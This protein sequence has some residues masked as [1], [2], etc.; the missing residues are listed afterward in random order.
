M[1][2]DPSVHGDTASGAS[3][4]IILSADKGGKRRPGAIVS[5]DFAGSTLAKPAVG[6]TIAWVSRRCRRLRAVVALSLLAV[7]SAARAEGQRLVWNRDWPRFRPVEYGATG[8]LVAAGLTLELASTQPDEAHWV[9]PLPLDQP[10]R[11]ALVGGNRPTRQVADFV[12][13][14]G[15]MTA[16]FYPQVVDATLVTFVLDGGNFDVAWQLSWM[17]AEAMAVG[18]L[19]TRGA[20]RLFARERPLRRGCGSDAFYDELCPF[21]GTAAS[22]PSGHTSMAFVGAGLTCVHH[23]Y[24]PLYG[25]GSPDL[26]ACIGVSTLAAATG[27]LRIVADRHYASDVMVAAVVGFG[28]GYGLPWL[29]HYRH[30]SPAAEHGEQRAALA[31]VPVS[32][33]ARF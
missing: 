8:V 21:R 6:P 18:F 10:I 32:L 31:T 12:S 23:Q 30:G 11:R 24:L 4:D 16:Q 20:H 14:L 33:T 9:G 15:W 19:L 17:N 2:E 26:A 13:D 7:G 5:V 27:V 22:F 28:V 3:P 1:I 29:L 25:G